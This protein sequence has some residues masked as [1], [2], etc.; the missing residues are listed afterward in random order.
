MTNE[1]LQEI[2]DVLKKWTRR[3]NDCRFLN[4]SEVEELI[5]ALEASLVAVDASKLFMEKAEKERYE[6]QAELAEAKE[7]IKYRA[8]RDGKGSDYVSNADLRKQL[9]EE[10][11]KNT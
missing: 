9:A 11:A 4:P 1:R 6:A 10:K 8:W 7:T 5:A 2:K 3:P